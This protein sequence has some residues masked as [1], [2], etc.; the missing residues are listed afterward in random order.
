[1]HIRYVLSSWVHV[2]LGHRKGIFGQTAMTGRV[3]EHPVEDR[4]WEQA[5]SERNGVANLS[6]SG[7]D[8]RTRISGEYHWHTWSTICSMFQ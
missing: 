7:L 5:M 1:M 3:V 2:H 8:L 6:A 4:I